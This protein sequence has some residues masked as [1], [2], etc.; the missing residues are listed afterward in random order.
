MNRA[1]VYIKNLFLVLLCVIYILCFKEFY[2]D[3]L[4]LISY[5]VILFTLIFLNLLDIKN[6]YNSNI[7]NVLFISIESLIIFIFT[8]CLF[9]QSF[10]YN[11]N[12][13]KDLLEPYYLDYSKIFNV[14]YLI[15][16]IK[17]LIIIIFLLIIYRKLNRK[18]INKI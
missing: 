17:F 10:I 8:R 6:N 16:N 13:Y 3:S 4:F 11:S 5:L 14:V 7:Y 12:Y 18:K 15:Q 1:L 2:I 9:D